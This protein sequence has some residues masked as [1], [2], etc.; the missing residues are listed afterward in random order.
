MF[1]QLSCFFYR[2]KIFFI[3]FFPFVFFFHFCLLRFFF[4][5]SVAPVN[6]G[7]LKTRFISLTFMFFF[8]VQQILWLS[9]L[10]HIFPFDFGFSDGCFFMLP[11]FIFICRLAS[12]DFGCKILALRLN[13]QIWIYI[14][15]NFAWYE[16]TYTDCTQLPNKVSLD[17]SVEKILK[18]KQSKRNVQNNIILICT[19]DKLVISGLNFM[20]IECYVNW[21]KFKSATIKLRAIHF[22][23]ALVYFG[24]L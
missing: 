8:H 15:E 9:F 2:L 5:C 3:W 19:W 11:W 14:Y 18:R 23:A 16:H 13:N 21:L 4:F 1:V 20:V 22:I 7:C 12:Y 17:I 24:S 10:W 6:R